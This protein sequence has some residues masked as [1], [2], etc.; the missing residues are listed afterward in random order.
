[1]PEPCMAST[2]E[3]IFNTDAATPDVD[4]L[5]GGRTVV[6]TVEKL[7]LLQQVGLSSTYIKLDSNALH[8]PGYSSDSAFEVIYIV[9]GGGHVQIVG[10]NG[11]CVLDTHVS[12][13]QLFV[14]PKFF[15]VSK[16]AG[17]EGMEWLSM[18]TTTRPSFSYLTGKRSVWMALSPEVKQASLNVSPELEK[19]ITSNM[20]K[21]AIF[22]PPPN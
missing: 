12:T 22:V 14:V 16:I 20:S 9:K 19:V 13:G 10:I 2:K 7:S 18:I 1:M 3:M 21:I 6:V 4:I 5:K 17:S 8:S 11:Q 15:A